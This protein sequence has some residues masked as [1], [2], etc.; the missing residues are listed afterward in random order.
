M[1]GPHLFGLDKAIKER[2]ALEVLPRAQPHGM[3]VY[4]AK[5]SG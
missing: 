4:L 2:E 3:K 5:S 1:D